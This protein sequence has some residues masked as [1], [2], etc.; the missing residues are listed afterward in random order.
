M[1]GFLCTGD[2][3]RRNMGTCGFDLPAY[4]LEDGRDC[5]WYD[6]HDAYDCVI[7]EGA[8]VL[9]SPPGTIESVAHLYSGGRDLGY[10]TAITHTYGYGTVY[11]HI[12]PTVGITVGTPVERGQTIGTVE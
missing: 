3:A 9:A 11:L 8:Q 10:Q 12:T 5:I 2:I 6:G 1:A 7:G 4:Y